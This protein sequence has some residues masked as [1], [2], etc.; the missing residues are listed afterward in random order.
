MNMDSIYCPTWKTD[1][2]DEKMGYSTQ[3]Q[4][5]YQLSGFS[6]SHDSA[7]ETMPKY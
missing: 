5:K 3:L 6:S 7:L 1:H 4:Y 2:S